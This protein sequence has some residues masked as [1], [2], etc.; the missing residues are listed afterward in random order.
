MPSRKRNGDREL[1]QFIM[2]AIAED[3]A[4]LAAD[5]IAAASRPKTE[6][7]LRTAA[8]L[9]TLD[10]LGGGNVGDDSVVFTGQQII[11]P[12][13]MQGKMDE[14][15]KFLVTYQESMETHFNMNRTFPFRPND[16]AAAFDRAMRRVFGVAGVGKAQY[17]MFGVTP[18]EYKSVPSGPKG[19]TI[20]VPWE[21]VEFSLLEASF[22]LEASRS[23]EY[24]IVGKIRVEAPKKHRNKIQG[25]FNVVEE[26]LRE[27]SIYRGKAITA[28]ASEPGFLDL[29]GVDP[30]RVIYTEEV[31][32]Q[33][34]LNLWDPL[35]YTAQ[36]RKRGVPIKRSVL[37]YGKNGTGKT[38]AG[39]LAALL[40]TLNGW[41]Y[42]LVRAEDDAMEALNTARMYSPSL[43]MIEDV[44][45][46][47]SA[48]QDRDRIKM[49]L[50]RLDNV[51]AKGGEVMVLF[52]SNYAHTLDKNVVRP[53]RIDAAIE[54]E[55]LDDPG[56]E[57]LV[58][59]LIPEELLAD[60]VDY[61]QFCESMGYT[62][63]H[64]QP[65]KML[66]AFAVEAINRAIRFSIAREAIGE[67]PVI[68]T[69]DL[70]TAAHGMAAHIKLLEEAS[71]AG[72]AK[73]TLDKAMEEMVGKVLAGTHGVFAPIEEGEGIH[74]IFDGVQVELTDK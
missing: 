47:A 34:Q 50:D 38:M 45:T 7:E 43:V 10:E 51:E 26:E 33:L 40:A 66:P 64:G 36:L 35:K 37:L 72:D 14:V 29:E 56:Y 18:P 11:L 55:A 69:G 46:L 61:A 31:E 16:V 12:E 32:R 39:G 70:L 67:D 53:G 57:R 17:S 27:R 49:V 1:S 60:D 13:D 65:Q 59:S 68:N 2:P 19:Q 15:V 41:T 73:P 52:T 5:Q 42:I 9:A 54:V 63:I 20:Q 25:F 74:S 23:A 22:Y 30:E 8:I 24:G 58:K 48:N 4:K 71:F 6:Q 28:H 44:D 62:D 3:V 21:L